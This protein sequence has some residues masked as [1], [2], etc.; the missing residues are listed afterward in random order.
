MTAHGVC[1]LLEF[2]RCGFGAGGVG[3]FVLELDHGRPISCSV[4]PFE[5]LTSETFEDTVLDVG[6]VG[7]GLSLGRRGVP[8]S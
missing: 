1:L 3:E 2:P 7:V 8:S 5:I 4:L 6:K